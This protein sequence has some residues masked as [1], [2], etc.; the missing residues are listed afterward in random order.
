VNASTVLVNAAQDAG[1]I[2]EGRFSPSEHLR[3]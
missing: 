2:A 3:F 1:V